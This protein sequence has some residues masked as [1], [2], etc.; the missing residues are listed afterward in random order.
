MIRSPVELSFEPDRDLG[1]MVARALQPPLADLRFWGVQA[2]VFAIAALL[3]LMT[4]IGPIGPVPPFVLICLFVVPVV[5]AALNFGLAGSL[6]TAGWTILLSLPAV[7]LE[8]ASRTYLWAEATQFFMVLF[9]AVFVGDRVER[10]VLSRLRTERAQM[11][12]R[13]MFEA[14]PAPTLL[15]SE[16]GEVLEANAAAQRIFQ[17]PGSG[18]LPHNLT[19]L[20]GQETATDIL[21]GGG[22]RGTAFQ[23]PVAGGQERVLRPVT[24]SW[25]FGQRSGMQVMFVDISEEQ[26]RADRA[27]AYA[28]WVLRGHE[29]ER[30]RIA[31]ELHDEPVQSLVHLCRQ[32]DLLTEETPGPSRQS[33]VDVRRLATS[34]SEDLRRIAQGLRPPSLDDLGLVAAVRRLTADLE[35]RTEVKTEL[36]VAG[37]RQRLDADTELGLFRI[38]QEALRNAERHSR[39]STIEVR[40]RFTAAAVVLVIEDDGI[41]FDAVTDWAKRGSLGLIG[42]Q[43]RAVL[44]GGEL[45]VDSRPGGGTAVQ[46]TLPT[47][48]SEPEAR[49]PVGSPG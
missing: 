25:A 21:G 42:M 36:S 14:S 27:D 9:V 6:A 43:E 29:E 30:Q 26:R 4:Q 2:L 11:A 15:L 45:A 19:E 24:T 22:G 47:R 28:A 7:L 46:A 34:I 49:A 41:G 48:R 17:R 13:Q 16:E 5:Y 32:L 44:L 23:L 12:L 31:K 38:A 3:W 18:A 33:M 1:R 39:A 10:E 20:V 40:L 35:R 8:P 37:R